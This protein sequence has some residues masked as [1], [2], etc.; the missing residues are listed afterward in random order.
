MLYGVAVGDAMG[1]PYEFNK[2]PKKVLGMSKDGHFNSR[3]N[4][5]VPAGVW[6]D[7]TSMTLLLL[8]SLIKNKGFNITC[9]FI[10]TNAEISIIFVN[11]FINNFIN[12]KFK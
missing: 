7:D 10:N 3:M 1:F 4:C 12:I 5:F 6:T 8:E 11:K 9:Q 2:P